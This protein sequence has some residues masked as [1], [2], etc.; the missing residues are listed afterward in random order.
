MKT[1]MF[2]CGNNKGCRGVNTINLSHKQGGKAIEKPAF[3][4]SFLAMFVVS[5]TE[6][7]LQTQPPDDPVHIST[8]PGALAAVTPKL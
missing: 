2:A 8:D 6:D 3:R 5:R 1:F 7:H 4:A